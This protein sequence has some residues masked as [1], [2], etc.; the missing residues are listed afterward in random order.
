MPG[1]EY[2]VY[3]QICEEEVYTR[4]EADSG[5]C[6]CCRDKLIYEESVCEED[7]ISRECEFI[8]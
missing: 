3:C 5:E 4:E 1:I 7:R 8:G 2:K 6:E